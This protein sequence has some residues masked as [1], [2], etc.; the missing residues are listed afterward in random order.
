VFSQSGPV[1]DINGALEHAGG[2]KD[3]FCQLCA[4]F[5]QESPTLMTSIKEAVEAE[6]A[7]LLR[8]AAHTL[9]GS[10]SVFCADEARQ[11]AFELETMGRDSNLNGVRECFS[12]LS[13][14]MGKLESA[15]AEFGRE[16]LCKS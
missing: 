6:D 1:F 16:Y 4:L 5:L 11:A 8:R 15:L 13:E 7:P 12:R 2:D 10:I 3:L 14:A 9:K